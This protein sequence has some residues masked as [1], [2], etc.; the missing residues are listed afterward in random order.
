MA[1]QKISGVIRAQQTLAKLETPAGTYTLIPFPR[2]APILA[3]IME[4]TGEKLFGYLNQQE[5]VVEGTLAG[6]N[7]YDAHLYLENPLP[8]QDL[9]IAPGSQDWFTVEIEQHFQKDASD[10]AGKLNKA[11]IRSAAALYHRIKNNYV[12]EVANFSRYLKVSKRRIEEFIKAL[13]SNPQNQGLIMKSR[14]F[15]V[16]R[17]INLKLLEEK[18]LAIAKK[19]SGQPPGFPASA[20]TLDLPSKV[21]LTV[22]VT[23]VKDQGLRGTC[24]AHTVAACLEAELI[25]KGKAKTN[26]NLSEQYL[27]WACKTVDGAPSEEGTFLEHAVEVLLNGVASEKLSGGIS[28]EI[29]WS[30]NRLPKANNESQGPL[31][32]TIRKLFKDGRQ[33]RI[34]K[35]TKINQN[36]IKALKKTLALGFCVG[37]SVRTYHFWEDDY[38]FREGIISLPLSLEPDG[39]HAICLVGYR[40]ND[41]NHSDGYF[42]FKNS[43]D[44]TWGYGRAD[45]GHGSLPYRYVLREA[46][47]AYTVES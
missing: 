30:Y 6:D 45:P 16:Q 32:A 27:Y 22:H 17:G 3:K 4:E 14:R 46:I 15:P 47:E 29:Q 13:E 9:R 5:A 10:I 2:R 7:L 1:W 41:E 11:G 44:V 38:A 12:T 40:D 28:T 19:A 24:V 18:G 42:I 31:P 21:D 20:I 39:A 25:R 43:W 26:L 23:P 36:S 37:L 35:Y 34:S 33:Q 8:V